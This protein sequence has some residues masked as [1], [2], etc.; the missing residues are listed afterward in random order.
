LGGKVRGTDA[1]QIFQASCSINAEMKEESAK[2]LN[3]FLLSSLRRV[4]KRTRLRAEWTSEEGI[5]QR[6][7]DC[8]LKKI[9][10]N[11]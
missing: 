6:F 1:G 10:E 7:F 4:E 11:E 3:S 2:E 9:T 8:A 5:I